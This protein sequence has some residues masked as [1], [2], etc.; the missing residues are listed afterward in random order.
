MG[1]VVPITVSS[2]TD[3]TAESIEVEVEQGYYSVSLATGW[4]MERVENGVATPVE[5]QLLSGDSQWIYVSRHST[6]W[7]R[8]QF[9][10][11]DHA[12]WFNGALNIDMTVYEN[13]DQYYGG[14]VAGATGNPGP[15][16]VAGAVNW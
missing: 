1:G 2:E 5:A 13:P 4:S 7:V 14:G 16:G 3:P 6:S 11:G 15:M 10:I 8:Y 9:G 12:L